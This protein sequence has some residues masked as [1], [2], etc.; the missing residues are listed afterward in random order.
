MS[1]EIYP[2]IDE[3][4]TTSGNGEWHNL[5]K[6]PLAEDNGEIG[7]A[8]VNRLCPDVR[9]MR[10]VGEIDG[11]TVVMP[12][13]KALVADYRAVRPEF[14]GPNGELSEYAFVP[15]HIPKNGY[16]VIGNCEIYQATKA[17]IKDCDAKIVT[18]GTLGSGRRFFL[19]VDIR[20]ESE[21][22]VCGRDKVLAYLCMV[23]SHDGTIAAKGYDSTVRIV[24]QNTLNWSLAAA[25]SIGFSVYHTGGATVAVA[26]MGELIKEILAGRA[27]FKDTMSYLDSLT[28]DAKLAHEIAT[29]YFVI[30]QS[31]GEDKL[32]YEL[33][34]RSKNAADEIVSLYKTGA[35][36]RGKTA[37]DLLN[38]ATDYWTN[39]GG[40]GKK[41]TKWER[42][43]KANF[44]GAA[45]HKQAFVNMLM[46]RD[47]V[48]LA[49]IG[50]KS[51]TVSV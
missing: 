2:P 16:K 51:L 11:Q 38:G 39:G 22:T 24:C 4:Y 36:N 7:D 26:K 31:A 42:V 32:N 19:S 29:A 44:G 33:S 1:H 37:Y 23:T 9:E 13:H 34:T 48:E 17:A 15:L 43:A 49:E 6:A 3:V 8:T 18:A 25:G 46:G 41:S 10:L 50:R 30:G 14:V 12:D 21:M 20:G 40:T 35:G 27:K 5:A 28:V 45:E 47:F